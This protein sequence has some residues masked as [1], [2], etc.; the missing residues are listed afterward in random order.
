[1]PDRRPQ[2]R[3]M[4]TVMA[5]MLGD[6]QMPMMMRRPRR[7]GTAARRDRERACQDR[8]TTFHESHQ[9]NLLVDFPE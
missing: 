4:M 5:I 8:Y 3:A 1:M 9:I 7:R 2:R 6:V